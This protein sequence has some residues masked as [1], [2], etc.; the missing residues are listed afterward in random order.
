MLLVAHF[1]RGVKFFLVR[2]CVVRLRETA[3]CSFWGAL[4]IFCSATHR[5][6]LLRYMLRLP[7]P[8]LTVLTLRF[9][10]NVALCRCK[11]SVGRSA[12]S[13]RLS[14]AKPA[15]PRSTVR[16]RLR[17]H[18]R[19]ATRSRGRL[20]QAA[21]LATGAWAGARRQGG[22]RHLSSPHPRHARQTGVAAA[23]GA[24]EGVWS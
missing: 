11:R 5:G 21:S 12:P 23:D 2:C 16:R 24:P 7:V 6:C 10:P 13:P 19:L 20:G 17:R 1:D 15:A 4:C 3:W 14:T 9:R 22:G 8:C 18:Q